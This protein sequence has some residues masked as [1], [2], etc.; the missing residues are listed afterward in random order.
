ML[1]VYHRLTNNYWWSHVQFL[2]IKYFLIRTGIPAEVCSAVKL[3]TCSFE[4]L[5]S[6]WLV[7]VCYEAATGTSRALLEIL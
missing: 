6:F 4:G 2:W 1:N 5:G 7:L 3:F